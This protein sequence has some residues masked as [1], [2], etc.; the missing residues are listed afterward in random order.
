ME[1]INALGRRK[2]AI[3]RIYVSEGSEETVCSRPFSTSPSGVVMSSCLCH[4]SGCRV[5][6]FTSQ[7]SCAAR[8]PATTCPRLPPPQMQTL[9][10]IGLRIAGG[11]LPDGYCPHGYAQQYA[12][13]VSSGQDRAFHCSRVSGYCVVSA[14]RSQSPLP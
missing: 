7:L 2:S 3:A 13:T 4:R 5:S 6:R 10:F 1:V 12:Y 11:H 14:Y 8:N 9:Y